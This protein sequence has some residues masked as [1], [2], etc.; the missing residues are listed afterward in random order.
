MRREVAKSAPRGEL[1][2]TQTGKRST[3]NVQPSKKNTGGPFFSER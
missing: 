1:P 2:A 3:L